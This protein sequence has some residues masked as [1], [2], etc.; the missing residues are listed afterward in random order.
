V[1]TGESFIIIIINPLKNSKGALKISHIAI[2][3]IIELS[4]LAKQQQSYS[5]LQ[6]II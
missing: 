4:R 5:T 3:I 2:I 6:R 1:D